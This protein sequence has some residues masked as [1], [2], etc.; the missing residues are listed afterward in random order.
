MTT[1][2]SRNQLALALATSLAAS[3]VSAGAHA[4]ALA[5]VVDD[6]LDLAQT[7]L[8]ACDASQP[9]A[10]RPAEPVRLEVA[11]SGRRV[12]VTATATTVA[13]GWRRCI[14]EAVLATLPVA[15]LEAAQVPRTPARVNVTVSLGTPAVTTPAA[16]RAPF[17]V[18]QRVTVQWG[19]SWFPAE[20][21]RVDG[22][23]QFLIHYEGSSTFH[24]EVVGL[25]R[26]RV[27]DGEAP[28]PAP[29]PTVTPGTPARFVVERP[30]DAAVVATPPPVA[31]NLLANGGFEA[32]ALRDGAWLTGPIPGWRTTAGPGGEVQANAAGAAAEGRQL[33]ELDS[34]ASSAIAQDV[35]TRAGQRYEISLSFSARPGTARGHNRLVISWGGNVV[36]RIDA[37][38]TGVPGT[39][40][41][42]V[43]QLVTATSGR[44]TLEL[45]D[46]GASDGMGTYID[47][48]RVSPVP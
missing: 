28:P 30:A 35:V 26:I 37:D 7:A 34:D 43:R 15:A 33:C 9:A 36:A 44:T 45:R 13:P 27:R 29:Q 40:W 18:G 25:D 31:V 32:A 8:S 22:M 3:A 10:Q 42:T 24:D 46:E 38:G 41:I 17:A 4:Q 20:V 2:T 47:D 14:E 6:R 16:P 19:S 21:M 23:D 5:D 39:R 1:Q 11:W 48:V 12:S